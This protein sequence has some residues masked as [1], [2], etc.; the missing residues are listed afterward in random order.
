MSTETQPNTASNPNLSPQP[1]SGGGIVVG[2]LASS[3]V[4][5]SC[6]GLAAYV[7]YRLNTVEEMFDK[8]SQEIVKTIDTSAASLKQEVN[9]KSSIL[10]KGI[11]DLTNQEESRHSRT[12]DSLKE[13]KTLLQ[14]NQVKTEKS[15]SGALASA[16]DDLK[17]LLEENNIRQAERLDEVAKTVKSIQ[18]SSTNQ[19]K[20]LLAA[21][22][23]VNTGL[24]TTRSTIANHVKQSQESIAQLI[25]LANEGHAEQL[26]ELATS[27]STDSTAE[28]NQSITKLALQIDAIQ[29]KIT[30]TDSAVYE[31]T[32][33]VPTWQKGSSAQVEELI[34]SAQTLETRLQ[35][36]MDTVQ[37]NVSTMGQALEDTTESILRAMYDTSEG[38]EGARIDLKS[39]IASQQEETTTHLQEL[40]KSVQGLSDELKTVN[41]SSKSTSFA[42]PTNHGEIKAYQNNL[43]EV[44]TTFNSL[45]ETL[46]EELNLILSQ[47][48]ANATPEEVALILKNLMGIVSTLSEEIG[49]QLDMLQA[50]FKSLGNTALLLEEVDGAEATVVEAPSASMHPEQRADEQLGFTLQ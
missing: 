11:L 8:R 41:T 30:S 39:R 43:A 26:N 21:I 1:K 24:E 28:M 16:R 22:Q 34:V 17:T 13:N 37:K 38:M 5:G 14:E 6:I 33:M 10:A 2:L 7:D 9:D 42:I 27:L 40:V 44:G 18:S 35:E 19:E 20:A 23:K 31:L 46:N 45:R 47:S 48:S 25:T 49:S 36:Q 4:L 12:M 3:V 50:G 29:K 15:L 32:Q